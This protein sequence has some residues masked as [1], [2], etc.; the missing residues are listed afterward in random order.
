M[1]TFPA[2]D[3]AGLLI[4]AAGSARAAYVFNLVPRA[5]VSDLRLFRI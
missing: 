3:A 1:W 4:G 2:V 5:R